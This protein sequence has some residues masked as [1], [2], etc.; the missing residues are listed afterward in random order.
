MGIPVKKTPEQI[1]QDYE[2]KSQTIFRKMLQVLMRAQRKV[3]DSAYRRVL[4]KV[5]KM[6]KGEEV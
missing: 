2:E 1:L 3:D 6:N 4:D 5:E